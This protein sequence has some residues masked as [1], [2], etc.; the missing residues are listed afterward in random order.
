V[1]KRKI[2]LIIGILV[3]GSIYS[4][5][6]NDIGRINTVTTAV[7]FLRINPD[8]RSGGMGDV[9]IATSADANA[10][11]FNPAKLVFSDKKLG[12]SLDY[13]PW[14]RNLGITDIFITH[15]AGYYKLDDYQALHTSFKFFSLGNI[16][17]TDYL[18]NINGQF[19]PREL[20]LDV[21]YNRKLG[22]YVGLGVGLRYIY[23]NLASGQ[24]VDNTPIKAGHAIGSDI[25][26]AFEKP[27]SLKGDKSSVISTGLAI[28]N[29]GSK[30]SYTSDALEKDYIPTNLGVGV[31]YRF[32]PN[33]S[34]EIG[35]YADINKLMV[36]TPDTVDSDNNGILDFKEKSPIGG[37][38]SSFADAPGG[39]KEEFKEFMYSTGLEY[40]YDKQFGARVG[41]FHE[42]TTK[43]NR[44]YF[45]AGVSVKYSVFG[46]DFSYLVPT[47]N[48]RNPLDNTFRFSLKFDFD[49]IGK[50]VKS[51]PEEMGTVPVDEQ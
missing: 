3:S 28:T 51:A 49:N 35:I 5:T 22:K 11:F 6:Q 21:G 8:A 47:S 9:G 20:A 38:F 7:P 43:G 2:L 40:W 36:P 50:K 48:R 16:T 23:S 4:Q 10:T 45:T 42:A 1:I 44:K 37:M 19:N 33:K 18:G 17:F 31:G 27:I 30:I 32:M 14:L 41:Y 39:A 15:F 24:Q 46:L 29:I 13:A 34:N 12:L 26:F 25:S